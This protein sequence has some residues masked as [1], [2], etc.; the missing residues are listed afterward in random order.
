MTSHVLVNTGSGTNP[1]PESLLS[2]H[3]CGLKYLDGGNSTGNAEDIYPCYQ[4][5]ITNLESQP[6]PPWA[7][8]KRKCLMFASRWRRS[9][10]WW[11]H[12]IPHVYLRRN[13][14]VD[15][16][17]SDPRQPITTLAS[18]TTEAVYRPMHGAIRNVG[19]TT[20]ELMSL[21]VLQWWHGYF[22]VVFIVYLMTAFHH[23][24]VYFPYAYASLTI[25]Y[26][27]YCKIV[28]NHRQV[29]RAR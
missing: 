26:I 14:W 1:L 16:S 29:W 21:N 12:G 5:K 6:H 3:Q 11:R 15:A 7:H 24:D 13:D 23:F 25:C 10:R 27:D 9:S 18:E 28:I 20:H 19:Q 17:Q 4:L 8:R 22:L 2:N